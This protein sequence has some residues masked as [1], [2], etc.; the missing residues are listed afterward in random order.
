MVYVYE[1]SCSV[2]E[3]TVLALLIINSLLRETPLHGI[4]IH[5]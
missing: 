3:E 2:K 1:L 5:L 4:D